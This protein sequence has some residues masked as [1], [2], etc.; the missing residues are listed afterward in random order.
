MSVGG[1]QAIAA[2]GVDT[3]LRAVVSEGATAR[4]SREEGDPAQGVGGLLV[5]HIDWVSKYAASLMTAADRP[6]PMRES[7][8]GFDDQRALLIAAGTV[9]SEIRAT[10]AFDAAAPEQV[11]V[12]IAP[13]ASHTGAFQTH[14]DEWERRVVDFLDDTLQP[15]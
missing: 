11:D 9:E 14:P 1:E 4:G 8:A 12:W 10:D 2:A 13:N 3:R 7:L 5:R 15:A 6:T